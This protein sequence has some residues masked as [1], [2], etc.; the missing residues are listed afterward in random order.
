LMYLCDEVKRRDLGIALRGSIPWH[1]NF[2]KPSLSS[3]V[4]WPFVCPFTG[5]FTKV[6][7]TKNIRSTH[8][9]ACAG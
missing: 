2:D 4:Y 6:S 3:I 9:T 5:G 1:V 8:H 7:S